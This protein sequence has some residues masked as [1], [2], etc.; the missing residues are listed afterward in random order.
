[1]RAVT[2]VAKPTLRPPPMAGSPWLER[3]IMRSEKKSVQNVIFY[4][5]PETFS[6]CW[7]NSSMQ[8]DGAS[9]G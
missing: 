5:Y 8:D 1:M 9:M 6:I 2:P 3:R 7:E 4:V